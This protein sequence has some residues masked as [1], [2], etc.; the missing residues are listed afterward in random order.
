M[1]VLLIVNPVAGKQKIVEH[2]EE[3]QRVFENAGH[4]VA[5]VETSAQG[6]VEAL[7]PEHLPG[8]DMIVCA[9]G[10]GTLNETVSTVLQQKINL[11]LGYIPTGSTNDFASSLGLEK[12]PV[13]AAKQ[14]AAGSP[15][16]LDAGRFG[17]RYFIYSA[18][19]GAFTQASYNTT[20]DLKNSIGH[21]AYVLEGMKELPSLKSYHVRV[22]ADEETHE[23]DYLFGSVS[24]ATTLGGVLH[25][26]ES[27]VDFSDGLFELMLVKMPENLI[28]FSRIV[29]S[30]MTGNF[31]RELITL[32]H[33]RHLLFESTED[34]P[35]SLDG[36]Y[37]QGGTRA[38]VAN[39]KE[40]ITLVH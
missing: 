24:N 35:W 40:A 34:I 9:G 12:K 18:S 7:L 25:L 19:F 1:K 37:A 5:I 13:A 39:L 10:D 15:M 36:E 26:D 27:L 16:R 31:D 20:Q 29:I 32:A 21:L 3:I 30:L 22:Q 4:T 6:S 38:E 11:P 23:G 8:T 33:S 14:I 17:D 2:R 28:E